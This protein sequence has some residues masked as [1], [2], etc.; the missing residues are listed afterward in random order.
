MSTTI[1]TYAQADN[2]KIYEQDEATG[3]FKLQHARARGTGL[4]C[5]SA[6]GRLFHVM[7]A[8]E[9]H[10]PWLEHSESTHLRLRPMRRVKS[11]FAQDVVTAHLV[12]ELDRERLSP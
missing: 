1:S 3:A 5:R 9:S 2:W 6:K 11:R 10:H 4:R 7:M 8:R 12:S